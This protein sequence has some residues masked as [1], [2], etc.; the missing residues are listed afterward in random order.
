MDDLGNYWPISL[1][2]TMYKLLAAIIKKR[3]E[4]KIDKY[5]QQTQ[6]GFRKKRGMA[7]AM[8]CI[9]RIVDKGEMTETKTILVLLD[10][11]KTFDK[12]EHEGLFQAL[13]RMNIPTKFINVIRAVYNKP[14]FFRRSRRTHLRGAPA[15]IRHKAR[16]PALTVPLHYIN[17]STI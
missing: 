11:E 10:W 6:H 2:S 15:R 16:M 13:R 14:T 17:D 5:L 3:L 1:L 4:N 8:Q 12:V 7:D 9:R